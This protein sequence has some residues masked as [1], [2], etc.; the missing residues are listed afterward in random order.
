MGVSLHLRP[1]ALLVATI[2]EV[3]GLA[4]AFLQND[5]SAHNVDILVTGRISCYSCL[6][7]GVLFIAL[8]TQ[9]AYNASER[10]NCA[11]AYATNSERRQIRSY[12]NLFYL[13][14]YGTSSLG[15][16]VP[17]LSDANETLVLW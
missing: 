3:E 2:I 9:M 6:N 15:S 10:R 11:T 12:P 5:A 7:C 8:D 14:P 1:H 16:R 17:F 4:S 13:S